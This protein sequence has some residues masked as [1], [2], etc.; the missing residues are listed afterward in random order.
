MEALLSEPGEDSG[1]VRPTRRWS[2]PAGHR[3]VGVACCGRGRPFACHEGVRRV[4]TP[5]DREG[6]PGEDGGGWRRAGPGL[7][8][9]FT[10][11]RTCRMPDVSSHARPQENAAVPIPST[12]VS[13]LCDLKEDGR[14]DETWAV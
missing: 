7:A 6:H 2:L 10:L 11:D 8:H 1:L 3:R 4:W 13:L 9:V 12:H 14:R 5:R